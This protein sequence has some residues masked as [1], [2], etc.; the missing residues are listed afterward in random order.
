MRYHDIESSLWWYL[1]RM[2]LCTSGFSSQ[3]F[4]FFLF[5]GTCD[6]NLQLGRESYLTGP[7]GT[8]TTA[9][10]AYGPLMMKKIT[11]IQG[12]KVDMK[13]VWSSSAKNLHSKIGVLRAANKG[14]TH[15]ANQIL[16]VLLQ[17]ARETQGL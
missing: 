15:A 13:R 12:S 8:Q 10:Y 1:V 3:N 2:R 16:P 5:L 4:S 17:V 6:L 11:A 14:S 9:L 7:E